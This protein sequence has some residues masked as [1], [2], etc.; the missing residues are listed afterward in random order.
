MSQTCLI[1]LRSLACALRDSHLLGGSAR[2]GGDGPSVQC[3]CWG[4]AGRG[5]HAVGLCLM[6]LPG[7]P[8]CNPDISIYIHEASSAWVA[9]TSW[10]SPGRKWLKIRSFALVEIVVFQNLHLSSRGWRNELFQIFPGLEIKRKRKKKRGQQCSILKTSFSVP[11]HRPVPS[12]AGGASL[13]SRTRLHR[14]FHVKLVSN[15][16][17]LAKQD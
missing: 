14:R 17:G 12:G 15:C 4:Q 16:S 1:V 2:A 9:Q 8:G 6:E 11:T 10:R 5:D 13:F 3:Q 7:A